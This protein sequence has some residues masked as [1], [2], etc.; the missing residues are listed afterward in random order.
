MF[1][2]FLHIDKYFFMVYSMC[3]KQKTKG[4]R[5][6]QIAVQYA[7]GSVEM[8]YDVRKIVPNC[9]AKNGN[10]FTVM[11][12]GGYGEQKYVFEKDLKGRPINWCKVK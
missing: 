5:N 6:M 10:K 8:I 7:D 1:C 3:R 2:A 11:L 9:Q 4:E 12:V